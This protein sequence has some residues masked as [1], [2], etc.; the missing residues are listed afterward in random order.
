[1]PLI[2]NGSGWE[3]GDAAI[4]PAGG[5]IAPPA[6]QGQTLAGAEGNGGWGCWLA[7]VTIPSAGSPGDAAGDSGVLWH[8]GPHPLG[9]WVHWDGGWGVLGGQRPQMPQGGSEN[10]PTSAGQTPGWGQ[11]TCGRVPGVCPLGVFGL[12]GNQLNGGFPA[13]GAASPG[14]PGLGSGLAL[15]G[16]HSCAGGAAGVINTQGAS[17]KGDEGVSS[18]GCWEG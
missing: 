11:G 10:K 12:P 18:W 2:I 13:P 5:S 14:L 16:G 6:L 8:W 9:S 17:L 3:R 4:T 7:R 15:A 1:M